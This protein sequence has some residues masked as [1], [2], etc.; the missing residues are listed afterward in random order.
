MALLL[1]LLLLLVLYQFGLVKLP[2]ASQ[3]SSANVG[4]SIKQGTPGMSAEEMLTAAQARADASKVHLKINGRPVFTTGDAEGNLY[5][6]NPVDN[7]FIMTVDIRLD[8]TDELI[9]QSGMMQPNSYIDNDKLLKVLEKGEHA[10][11]ADLQFFSQDNPDERVS[12][13][14]ASLVIKIEN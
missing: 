7:A 1:A 12:R 13:S 3:P 11:T 6:V 14:S 4:G 5:I 8:A 10:A 9:Y 2:W